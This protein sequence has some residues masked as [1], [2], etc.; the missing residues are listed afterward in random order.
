MKWV[1]LVNLGDN[2]KIS[3]KEN[4]EHETQKEN[5]LQKRVL[6][7]RLSWWVIGVQSYCIPSEE[8]CRTASGLFHQRT[9]LDKIFTNSLVEGSAWERPKPQALLGFPTRRLSKLSS[10]AFPRIKGGKRFH[11]AVCL[12]D[13]SALTEE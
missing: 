5:N 7:S 4:T 11:G 9:K 8:P 10:T 13:Y 12:Y 1:Q 2:Y 3:M 6:V